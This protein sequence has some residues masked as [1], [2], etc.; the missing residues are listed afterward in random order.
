MVH[1]FCA[2]PHCEVMDSTERLID[3]AIQ[4]RLLSLSSR[5]WGIADEPF[6]V[7]DLGQVIRQHRRWRVN[8]PDVLPFFAVKCNPD[9]NL[10]KLLA[11][12]GTGFDCASIEELRTVLSLGVDPSRIIFANPC[13]SASSL[14][15][16][17]RT[18][19]TRTT[20]DNLDELDNI[21]TFLPNAQLVLRIFASDSDALINL[22][23]KFGATVETSLPLLQ[24]ARELGLD[25]C[26]VSFHVGTGASNTSAYVDAIRHA[27]IVFG[28]GKSLGFDMNLLDI[29][30]GFQDC[31]L[32]DIA[33]SL[34]PM[35]KEEFPS[36]VRLIAEPGRY[37]AR[38]AYTLVCKVLSR[39]RHI[40]TDD[41]DKPDMLYQN[42]G[43]YGSFMNVLIEKE[44][45]RPS[46]VAYTWPFHSHDN[47]TR[48]KLQEHRYT[49]WGP[50]CDS[51]DCVAKDVPMNSEI[52]I[53]DWLKYKNMGAYTTA[54]ATQFN[55]FSNQRD[56]IYINTESM[57][58]QVM[59]WKALA[60]LHQDHLR[61]FTISV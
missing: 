26:G 15:F 20:F 28:Y 9:P 14:V 6:F 52:R 43:V 36:G 47:D 46:L 17:A 42:D 59:H 60:N 30:G 7:A 39:R 2:R 45:V 4:T 19:V 38:S 24:R 55:G 53:G 12:L 48:R 37:Y 34:R 33:C 58:Y 32:E 35:L 54:T 41:Q 13:K 1:Q 57:D 8:L 22:G 56:V 29:G 50:T 3:L 31:N 11:D 49:I 18:G 61:T 40:G 23:E 27:K 10:L 5:G 25:V 44:I 21:R 16:A 51:V